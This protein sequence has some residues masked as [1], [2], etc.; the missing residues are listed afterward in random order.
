M[1][2]NGLAHSLGSV[3]FGRLLPGVYSSPLLL[4]ASVWLLVCAARRHAQPTR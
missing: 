4:A 3:Y 2:L 1:F